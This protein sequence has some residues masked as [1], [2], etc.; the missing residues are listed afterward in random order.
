MPTCKV[1]CHC[2][3][4]QHQVGGQKDTYKHVDA[5]NDLGYEAYIVHDRPGF[6]LTWFDNATRVI[7]WRTAARLMNCERDYVVLP[8]DLGARILEYRGRKIIFNKSLWRGFS[9]L[10]NCQDRDPYRHPDVLAVLAMSEHNARHLRL[11]YPQVAVIRVVP[12]IDTAVFGFKPWVGR[13]RQIAFV[14][15][16]RQ[17]VEALRRIVASRAAVGLNEASDVSWLPLTN[18]GEGALA[19]TLQES[20][21]VVFFSA[22]EGLGRVALEAMACGCV[23]VGFRNGSLQEILPSAALFEW[24]DLAGVTQLIEDAVSR[25]PEAPRRFE[26]LARLGQERARPYAPHAHRASVEAAWRAILRL[27]TLAARP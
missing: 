27:E 23:V 2:Y 8:E 10:E 4:H 21:V 9:S 14:P 7:D 17:S 6:R 18:M 5:L 3:S 25:R 12:H 11:A 19:Q 15:K 22:E 13:R 24:G 16:C 26:E 1:F 20:L